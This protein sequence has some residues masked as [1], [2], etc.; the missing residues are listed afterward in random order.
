[1][2]LEEKKLSEL[3]STSDRFG[4]GRGKAVRTRSNFRQ[5]SAVKEEKLS[6]PENPLFILDEKL[7]ISCHTKVSPGGKI[8]LKILFIPTVSGGY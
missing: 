6:E 4:G 7:V 1:M 8:H 2:V 5:G 3:G